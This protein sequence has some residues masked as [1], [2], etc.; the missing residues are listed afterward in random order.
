VFGSFEDP[1][2]A[3]KGM[4]MGHV[5]VQ[6]FYGP[7]PRNGYARGFVLLSYMMTPVTYATLSGSFYGAEFKRF[8]H[9]YAY[10][11]AWWAHAED[12]RATRTQSRS[13]RSGRTPAACPSRA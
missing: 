6:D 1:I 12:C 7:D 13:I 10:T 3:F 5:M 2:N 11:A 8:L 9:N 4:Q